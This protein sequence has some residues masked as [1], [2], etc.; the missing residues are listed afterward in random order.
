[1]GSRMEKKLTIRYDEI[2]DILYIDKVAPYAE[3]DSEMLEDEVVARTNPKTGEIETL[4]ILFFTKRLSDNK[5]L[6]LA[7]DAHL[8]AAV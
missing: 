3:Q 8:E 7:I 4:E 1:M 5:V 2:G 6:E